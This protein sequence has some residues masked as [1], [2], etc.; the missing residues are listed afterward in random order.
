MTKISHG[1]LKHIF[2][3]LFYRIRIVFILVEKTD[4][5][6]EQQLYKI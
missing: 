4:S 3:K 6:T 2:R 1:A 5:Q